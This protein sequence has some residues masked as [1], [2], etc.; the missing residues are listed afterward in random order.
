MSYRY[1]LPDN[2]AQFQCSIDCVQCYVI[3]ANGKRCRNRT[4]K[5]VPLCWMHLWKNYNVRVQPSPLHGSGLFANRRGA[6]PGEVVFKTG[7]NIIFF[8]GE[9]LTDE[10]ASNRY[11]FGGYDNTVPYGTITTINGH[12]Y[13]VDEACRR[14]AAI[15]SNYAKGK[16]V[17]ATTEVVNDML[18]LVATK[19]IRQ[20]QEILWDYDPVSNEYFT[21]ERGLSTTRSR[22]I[23]P[24]QDSRRLPAFRQTHNIVIPRPPPLP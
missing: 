24:A 17:N 7:D 21:N 10:V 1:A 12:D 16:K 6:K 5:T 11:D 8:G 15:Y 3:G 18:W 13:P 19:T 23:K 2:T 14:S 20:G 4:C 22:K 9:V